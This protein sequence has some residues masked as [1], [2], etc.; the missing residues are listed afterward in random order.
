MVR[1]RKCQQ[2]GQ[3]V[4]DSVVLKDQNRP[5]IGELETG[6]DADALFLARHGED[7]ASV[8]GAQAA[9]EV[10]EHDLQ[11]AA[12]QMQD[13]RGVYRLDAGLARNTT[14]AAI[15]CTVPIR[16]IGMRARV[17]A[18]ISGWFRCVSSQLPPSNR[19]LP[20][21]TVLALISI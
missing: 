4:A 16:P 3:Q 21:E 12:G 11:R 20:G 15:S 19:V 13:E 14:A 1:L 18:N 7:S 17:F 2:R 5:G 10:I 9:D 8:T 6:C